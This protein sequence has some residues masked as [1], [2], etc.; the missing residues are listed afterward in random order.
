MSF[1]WPI[2]LIALLVAPLV[3]AAAWLLLHR[4]RR[5]AVRVTSIALVRTALPARG[6]WTRRVPAALL[7]LGLV[8]LSV[9]AARPQVSVPV[10]SDGTTIILAF[11]V[12]S[13]MCATDVDP[14]RLTV[15]KEAA[16]AFVQEQAGGSQIGLVAFSGTAGLVVPPTDDTDALVDAIDALTTS[17]GTAIGQAI[18]A[19]ID[20]IAEIDSSVAATG[21][22]VEQEEDAGYAAAAVVVLTDGANSQGVEPATAAEEAA[23]RGVRVYTI[24]FGT[25]TAAA[26]VCDSSQVSGG[27][28]GGGGFGGGGGQN[29]SIDE[30]TLTDVAD[31]TGGEYY[32]AENADQ[33]NS[34]LSGLPS[35][36]TVVFE[37]LDVASWFAVV[38]GLFV[39]GA[40]GLSLWWSR[41]R[42]SRIDAR[43]S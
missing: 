43:R 24:G 7:V 12:S 29:Q 19:S 30:A 13:S 18:L 15:A 22:E 9:G 34:A 33:L 38:G 3:L 42:R 40:V 28:G 20:A 23:A 21:V 5:S 35:T 36:I 8:V 39:A 1:A 26:S 27:T 4:R 32:R 31:V 17:R 16:T 25:D 14:N 11:D 37:D 41:P 2:A 6:R 10:A